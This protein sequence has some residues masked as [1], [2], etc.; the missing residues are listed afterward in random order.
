VVP[1]GVAPRRRRHRRSRGVSLIALSALLVGGCGGAGRQDANEPKGSFNLKLLHA[2][3]PTGQAVA[4]PASLELSVE[5]AGSNAAPNV[6]V[7]VDSFEYAENYAELAATQRPIWVIERGPGTIPVRPVR[8]QAVSP[9][10]GGLTNDVNTWALGPLAA[11]STRTFRWL[12]VPVKS[13]VRTVHFT[14]AAGLAGKARALSPSGSPV[15]GQFN[16]DI[17]AAPPSRH[18][19]PATGQVVP[20][21][22][23]LVP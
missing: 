22:F 13:G 18:V 12:V 19:N 14:V 9:P 10:G 17:A 8:S 15:E 16:V 4:R 1:R 3:F 23:P 20:G 11:G 5:N 6:A 7:S 2:S 21:Q